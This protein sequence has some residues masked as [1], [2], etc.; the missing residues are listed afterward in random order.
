MLVV[1]S[2][3]A[4][5]ERQEPQDVFWT[6]VGRGTVARRRWSAGLVNQF[7]VI[8][9]EEGMLR[10]PKPVIST[11]NFAVRAHDAQRAWLAAHTEGD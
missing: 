5:R 8:A 2:L 7:R 3:L 1:P 4:G 10:R 6:Q 11:T 9:R